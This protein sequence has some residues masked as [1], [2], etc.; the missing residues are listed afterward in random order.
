MNVD[1][2]SG[3]WLTL[4]VLHGAATWFLVGLIW[5]IQLIHYPSFSA[6]DPDRYSSFQQ[7]HM[8]GMGRLIAAPWLV[9]G[10]TV[11]GLFVFAPTGWMRLLATAGGLLELVVIGVTIRSSIPAHEALSTGFSDDAHKRLLRSNWMRTAAWTSRGL[12]ALVVLVW[13]LQQ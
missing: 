11:L 13:T 2:D 1:P 3:I 12:I 4:V 5:T 7:T 6:I 9:E 8:V 10:L